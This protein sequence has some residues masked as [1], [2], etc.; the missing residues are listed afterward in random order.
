MVAYMRH[1]PDSRQ[2][3]LGQASKTAYLR[4]RAG[5][6]G[7]PIVQNVDS[8]FANAFQ[9][10]PWG[11]WLTGAATQPVA[12]DD[13]HIRFDVGVGCCAEIRSMTPTVANASSPD[14]DPLP[15]ASTTSVT[16]ARDAMLAWCPE[17][18]VATSQADHSNHVTVKLGANS[19]LLW[20]DE[21]QVEPRTGEPPGTWGSWLRVAREGWP[22]VSYEL[23]IGP[24]SPLW[25][26]PAILGGAR[27]VTSIV[28]VDPD[29]PRETWSYEGAQSEDGTVKGVCLPLSGPGA[30]FLVWGPDLTECR[31]VL[32]LMLEPAGIPAWVVSRLR[33]VAVAGPGSLRGLPA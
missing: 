17:P 2:P 9:P 19:R 20:A 3:R 15:S 18:G 25:E 22:V 13:L 6:G 23:G 1:E 26:S 12:G 4:V 8:S 29:H 24:R 21:F 16:V 33:T 10:T 31:A 30:Q 11:A 27:A 14:S 28:I 32:G 5:I 7:E